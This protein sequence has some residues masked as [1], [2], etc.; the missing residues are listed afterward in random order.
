MNLSYWEQTTF[1]KDIDVIVVGS[2]IVGLTTAIELKQQAPKLKVV[3]LERGSLPSGASTKNAGFACFGSISELTNDLEKIGLDSLLT[4]V[5]MRWKGLQRLRQRVGDK[6]LV[7][8]PFGGYELF[9]NN[10]DFENY[11]NRLSFFNKHL[12]PIIGQQNIFTV[13]N[14]KIKSFGFKNIQQLVFNSAE[15]QIHTG[16][17]M[18]ALLKIATEKGVDIING[19]TV[20]NLYEE[21]QKVCIETVDGWK[22]SARKVVVAVNGFAQRLFP[23]LNVAPARNQ[24]L[25]TKPIK[26][27]PFKGTFH[28]DSGYYY[29]RNVGNRVLFGGGRNLALEVETTDKFGMTSLIQEQLSK[30]LNEIILPNTDYEVDQWWSGILGVGNTKEPILKMYSDRIG[31]AVRLGGMGVA[32]GSL[33]GAAAAKMILES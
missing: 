11:A 16:Q 15:G 31:V 30:M 26:N 8:K 4:L 7:F 1:F 22:L 9:L 27:L 10:Q 32:I 5:E 6:P 18:K 23:K 13:T 29:F 21:G 25:I 28:Y 2:G 3:V 24:V 14:D 20:K 12:A 19:I 17:M 33:I